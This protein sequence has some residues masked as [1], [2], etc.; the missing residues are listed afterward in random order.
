MLNEHPLVTLSASAFSRHK[1][2]TRLGL[3]LDL[4]YLFNFFISCFKDVRLAWVDFTLNTFN[5]VVTRHGLHHAFQCVNKNYPTR[6]TTNVCT[7][8]PCWELIF[9]TILPCFNHNRF[10]AV[11][12][13][14]NSL[15]VFL[16]SAFN[17]S[18]VYF[19]PIGSTNLSIGKS[20]FLYSSKRVLPNQLR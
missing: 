9:I 12:H 8:N 14:P 16:S 5:N 11:F 20:D 19:R 7:I 4:V 1:K 6:L 15:N 3:G 13:N 2:K 10:F 18:S 17:S